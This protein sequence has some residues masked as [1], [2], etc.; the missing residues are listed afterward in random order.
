MSD[1]VV[2]NAAPAM[3]PVITLTEA[4]FLQLLEAAG[5][6]AKAGVEVGPSKLVADLKAL[7]GG[8]TTA[9]KSVPLMQL[10]TFIMAAIALALHFI[11]LPVL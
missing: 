9:A 8:I 1:P 11:K 5:A 10:V 3:A 2:P 4:S 7:P 6:K